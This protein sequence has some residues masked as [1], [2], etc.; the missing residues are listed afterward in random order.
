MTGSS[1]YEKRYLGDGLYADYDGYQIRLYTMEGAEVFL[2]PSTYEA[3]IQYQ[4]GL[5]DPIHD[6]ANIILRSNDA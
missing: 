6:D 1:R 2:E 4:R 3:L 5:A